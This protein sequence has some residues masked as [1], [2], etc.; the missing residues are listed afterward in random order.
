MWISE[1][2]LGRV[3]ESFKAE[4][5]FWMKHS[6]RKPCGSGLAAAVM[7][8]VGRQEGCGQQL[9]AAGPPGLCRGGR[10]W[11]GTEGVC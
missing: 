11:G 2:Q 7:E 9:H 10:Q 1:S 8:V 3:G 4:T 5:L 6:S